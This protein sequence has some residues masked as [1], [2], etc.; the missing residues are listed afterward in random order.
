MTEERNFTR[1]PVTE[2]TAVL[3]VRKLPHG[4]AR[5]SI[6]CLRNHLHRRRALRPATAS[7]PRSTATLS[8]S[9]PGRR[10]PHLRIC[11]VRAPLSGPPPSRTHRSGPSQQQTKATAPSV[12]PSPGAVRS[13]SHGH[14]SDVVLVPACVLPVRCG[15]LGVAGASEA[16][17]RQRRRRER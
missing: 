15:T 2:E 14:R 4:A 17:H 5:G 9:A 13:L 1:A 12:L 6:P 3:Y 7:R 8:A 11:I 10:P 16:R